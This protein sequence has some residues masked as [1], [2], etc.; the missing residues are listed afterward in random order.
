MLRC[1]WKEVSAACFTSLLKVECNWFIGWIAEGFFFSISQIILWHT[2][3]ACSKQP[4]GESELYA[5]MMSCPY[6]TRM[7]TCIICIC[8][9]NN[10]WVTYNTCKQ[11]LFRV[12]VYL[13]TNIAFLISLIGL[14][15]PHIPCYK[16]FAWWELVSA[17]SAIGSVYTVDLEAEVWLSAAPGCELVWSLLM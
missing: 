5:H 14:N 1:F 2:V 11:T 7:W 15:S 4:P 9:Q 8:I 17:P 10:M 12:H 3:V 6:S 13:P 16:M